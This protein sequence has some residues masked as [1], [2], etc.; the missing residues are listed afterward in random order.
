MEMNFDEFCEQEK[1]YILKNK[2]YSKIE[3]LLE[4]NSFSPLV[5]VEIDKREGE[6]IADIIILV[7]CLIKEAER[8]KKEYPLA[9]LLQPLIPEPDEYNKNIFEKEDDE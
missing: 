1:E 3:I 2:N 8:L 6:E 5:Q 7:D 4:S 9:G